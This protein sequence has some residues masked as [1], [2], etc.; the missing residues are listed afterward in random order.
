M[1]MDC[2]TG[3]ASA[4][5]VCMLLGPAAAGAKEPASGKRADELPRIRQAMARIKPLHAR[6][7]KPQ[8]G[9]WLD[10]H[11][12]QGQS[13]AEYAAGDPNRPNARRTTMYIQPLGDFSQTQQQL[14]D[15]TA[16]MLSRFYDVP[17]KRLAPIGLAK[18]PA[19]AQRKHPEWGD[20]QILT[21]YVLTDLLKPQ[22]PDDAVAVLA[23]TATDLWPGEGWNFVFGQADLRERVGVWSLYRN[24]DPAGGDEAYRLCLRRT[25]KTA[26]HETGHM[27]GI[28]HCTA[29]ECGMNGSNHRAESDRQP[30]YFCPECEAKVWW[31]CHCDPAPRYEA[32]AAYA[33]SVGLDEEATFWRTSGKKLAR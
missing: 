19:R 31:A 5:I 27:L 25:L 8:S 22:R 14:I 13:F 23:L 20:Q 28:L 9:D 18:I 10:R 33:A 24:G 6:K 16:G 1:P 4:L 2:R 29:Y 17:V 12:E 15:Q 3:A 7:S 26:L 32:L 11:R 21:T 30:I